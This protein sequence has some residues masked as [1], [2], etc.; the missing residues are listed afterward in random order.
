MFALAPYDPEQFIHIA[1]AYSIMPDGFWALLSIIIAFYFG[2]RMQVTRKQ[3][4]L[5]AQMVETAKQI[6]AE[7]PKPAPKKRVNRVVEKWRSRTGRQ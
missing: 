4:V 2:G 3:M 6:V 5:E 7:K 1:Q